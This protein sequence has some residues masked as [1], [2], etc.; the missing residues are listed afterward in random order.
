MYKV[1]NGREWIEFDSYDILI[2]WLAKFNRWTNNGIRNGFLDMTGVNPGD[3]FFE[4]KY[5]NGTTYGSYCY[6]DHRITDEYENS[7]YDR[8]LIL[9]VISTQYNEFTERKLYNNLKKKQKRRKP[10]Y[11]GGRYGWLPDTAYPK[12]RRGPWPLIHKPRKMR[13]CRRIRTT[14]ERRFCCG[15][16]QK[17]FNRGSRGMN[18]PN[19]WD[20]IVID[21][22]NLGWK[23]QGKNRYQWENGIKT[24]TKH[25]EGKGTYVI[26]QS[27]RKLWQNIAEDFEDFE[28]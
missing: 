27:K 6:R 4:K 20:E 13:Y 24:R 14:N 19:S 18:L 11:Y 22:G 3:T 26:K 10:S 17:E 9:D 12:F 16:E 1:F 15:I 21:F 7:I 8:N 2:C 28:E 23:S 5:W 25:Q